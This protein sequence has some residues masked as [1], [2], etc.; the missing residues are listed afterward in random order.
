MKHDPISFALGAIDICAETFGEI[1]RKALVLRLRE[2]LGVDVTSQ[3]PWDR[4]EAPQGQLRPDG[5]ELIPRYVGGEA[6]CLFLEGASTIWRFRNGTDLLR[7]LEECSALEFYVCDED[8]SYLLCSNHH[9]FLIGWGHASAW[10]DGL[11]HQLDAA[12][13]R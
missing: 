7:L 3:A 11:G 8:A 12:K 10:V 13:D 2:R 6:C 9:D 1:E 5:W 4:S